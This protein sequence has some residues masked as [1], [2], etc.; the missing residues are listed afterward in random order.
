M[1]FSFKFL[2]HKLPKPTGLLSNQL[3]DRPWTRPGPVIIQTFNLS[4]KSR[5]EADE[6]GY[7]RFLN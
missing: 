4:Q 2:A 6:T 3:K 1:F 7:D 5:K